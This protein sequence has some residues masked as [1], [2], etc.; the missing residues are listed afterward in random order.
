MS[1][2]PET[3]RRLSDDERVRAHLE[4]YMAAFRETEVELDRKLEEAGVQCWTNEDRSAD[5][6]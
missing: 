2:V 1:S 4:S 3:K 5:K 6:R